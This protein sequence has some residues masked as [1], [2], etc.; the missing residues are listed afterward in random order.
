M[1][2]DLHCREVGSDSGTTLATWRPGTIDPSNTIAKTHSDRCVVNRSK[3][4]CWA[5]HTGANRDP[6]GQKTKKK[7]QS[8]RGKLL[9]VWKKRFDSRLVSYRTERQGAD[10]PRCLSGSSSTPAVI[11]SGGHGFVFVLLVNSWIAS[12]CSFRKDVEDVQTERGTS[13]ESKYFGGA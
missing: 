5:A 13:L 6:P 1:G 11:R 9:R 8:V 7:R 4:V 3:I 12:E 2:P 10:I